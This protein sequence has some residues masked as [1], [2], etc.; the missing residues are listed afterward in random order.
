MKNIKQ[1]QIVIG[2]DLGDKKHAVCVLGKDGVILKEYTILN[3]QEP[4]QQLAREYPG[5]RV[6]IETGTH[7]PWISRLLTAGGMEVIVANSRK[8][9]AIYQNERK[10]DE[11]DARILAKIARVDSNLLHPVQHVSEA[12]Q[13]DLLTI[14]LRDT[15]VR[16]R[17]A[18]INSVR[19]TLKSFGLLLKNPST[20]AFA[21]M[22]R[23]KLSGE[24]RELLTIVEPLLAVLDELTQRI[25]E[26]DK[27]IARTATAYAAV[28]TLQSIPGVGPITSLCY[29]LTIE[30]PGRFSDTRDVAAYLGLVPRRDQ[31][32]SKDKQ[33]PIS[34]T[35]N[36]YLRG[37]LVQSAQYILGPFGPES[38]LRQHGLKLAA[39][40]GKAAKKKAV[41]AVARKL[42][43]LLL[44]MWQKGSLY[45]A[46]RSRP[47]PAP[48]LPAAA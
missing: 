15:L 7:S 42:A 37:L 20:P 31:S 18:L 41:I 48:V 16:Q 19:S 9:R 11:L 44:A 23:T 13:K 3:Q 28:T 8:L 36:V 34:K 10:S 22:T 47:E 5:A 39:R 38:D 27:T 46:R 4:L 2:V 17:V 24:S 12:S 40:G 1:S 45:E 29:V 26:T 25:R 35:G 14:K 33:M 32:G 21:R 43:V 6:A 30:D